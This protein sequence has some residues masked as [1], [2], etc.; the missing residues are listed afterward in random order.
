MKVVCSD[1]WLCSPLS[2]LWL[3]NRPE[4]ISSKAEKSRSYFF[5]IIKDQYVA[6][7]LRSPAISYLGSKHSY[8]LNFEDFATLVFRWGKPWW[9]NVCIQNHNTYMKLALD[10]HVLTLQKICCWTNYVTKFSY[11]PNIIQDVYCATSRDLLMSL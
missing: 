2:Q 11:I 4:D 10:C 8:G 3:S 9:F 6:E 1:F 7:R 5:Q